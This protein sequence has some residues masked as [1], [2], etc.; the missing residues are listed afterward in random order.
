MVLRHHEVDFSSGALVFPGGK[1]ASG[2]ADPRLA[3]RCA[4]IDGLTTE[5]IALR[6][7][8]IRE[9]F[10]ESGLLL[11]REGRTDEIVAPARATELGHRYRRVLDTGEMGIATML[12]TEDLVLACD[13]LVPFAHWITP[14]HLGKRFD[15]HFYLAPAPA[16]QVAVHDGKEM[17]DSH[18][19]RPADALADRAAGKRIIVTATLFNLRKLDRSRTVAEAFA[20]ARAQRIVTVTPQIAERPGGRV[21]LIPA[22]ADYHATEWPLSER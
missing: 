12:E 14:E 10:E 16:E 21:L 19:I 2:D 22:E 6:V 1:I 11:A 7:G 3:S 18:W 13:L 4:G 20:A 17:V 8:A 5:Q 9:A 15:T